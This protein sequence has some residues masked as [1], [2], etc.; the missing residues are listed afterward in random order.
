[1]KRHT[2]DNALDLFAKSAG[3]TL[4][5]GLAIYR[6]LRLHQDGSPWW[7][8]AGLAAGEALETAAL[9]HGTR[10]AASKRW[11]ELEPAA[12]AH[13]RKV[14]R[15][16]GVAGMLEGGIW[17]SWRASVDRLSS[18]SRPRQVIAG[19]I[20][21]FVPMHLKHQVE[22]A[23]IRD[24]PFSTALL[25]TSGTFASAMEVAGA[26]ACLA[27]IEDGHVVLAGV[28][29]GGGLMIEHLVLLRTLGREIAARDIRRPRVIA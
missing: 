18:V 5:E 2:G 10:R 16:T 20:V 11:G 13:S 23:A 1:V 22:S 7:G 12:R 3:A 24:T 14:D 27:L 25:S 15:I 4:I 17:G 19:G 21:L 26:V 29:L 6:W 9:V 28:A 8:F